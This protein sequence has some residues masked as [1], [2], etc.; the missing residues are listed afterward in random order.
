MLTY[1]QGISFI[2]HIFWFRYEINP[3]VLLELGNVL[4]RQPPCLCCFGA[5][6]ESLQSL[7]TVPW[8]LLLVVNILLIT[9]ACFQNRTGCLWLYARIHTGWVLFIKLFLA[10]F[11]LLYLHISQNQKPL[12]PCI[13]VMF[14]KCSL[15]SAQSWEKEPL[16][17]LPTS[18]WNTLQHD[19]KHSD[20]PS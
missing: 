9:V 17:S 6:E 15:V 5:S 20:L 10:W 18:A 13:L 16:V 12:L 2:A 19:R 11:L 3:V 1:W 14:Y 4:V 8:D 7:D